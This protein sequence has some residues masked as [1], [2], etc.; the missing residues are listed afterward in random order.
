MRSFAE[1][2][3]QPSQVWKLIITSHIHMYEYANISPTAEVH[4]Y[5]GFN[6]NASHVLWRLKY[7]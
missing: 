3:N 5:G 2:Y 6:V 4:L 1:N 7:N